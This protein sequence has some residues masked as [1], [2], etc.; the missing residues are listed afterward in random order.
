MVQ[1]GA[2]KLEVTPPPDQPAAA[3]GAA[4]AKHLDRE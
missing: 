4:K 1:R 2:P 3:P